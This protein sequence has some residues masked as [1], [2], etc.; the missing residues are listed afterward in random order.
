MLE[1]LA[2]D[3]T[4]LDDPDM[5]VR[6]ILQVLL[7]LFSAFF[8]ASETA[9]FSLSRLDLH[10]LRRTR[11][12][13]AENIHALLDQPRRLIISI[14]SGNELV[15]VA[16]AANLAGILLALYGDE[17]ALWINILVMVPLLLLFGEVIPKTI[18]VT[19]PV[20]TSTRLIAVPL[21][22]WVK[23]VSP[24]RWAVRWIADRLT[25]LL[26]GTEREAEHILHVDEFRSLV[27]EVAEEGELDATERALIYKLLE[28]DD[29]EI[30]EI[31]TPRTQTRFLSADMTVPDM[32]AN[33]RKFRHPRVPV[34]SKHRDN[35]VGIIHAEDVV[36]IVMDNVDLDAMRPEQLMHP[37]VFV[38]LTKKVDEMVDFFRTHNARA[39]V[40]LNEFGGVEGF[41]TLRA[42][43]NFIFG[44][45]TGEVRGQE[46]YKAQDENIYQV[47]GD[48][49]LKDFNNLTHFGIGDQRMTTIGGVVLRHLDRL[50]KVDD[51]VTVEDV[52]LKVS[53][54]DGHRIDRLVAGKGSDMQENEMGVIDL[55][56]NP[57]PVEETTPAP[58]ATDVVTSQQQIDTETA[59]VRE[60]PDN[61]KERS[62]N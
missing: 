48:M 19:N 33:F 59:S 52:T 39:A 3:T 22:T 41:I 62:A 55:M 57:A 61:A 4:R 23:L 60:A 16:A 40:V 49:K 2:F 56:Q 1:S 54:M 46:L 35:I 58:P 30:V 18:S 42:V 45:T 36:R 34:F 31:M 44:Q 8:S 25:T 15:N 20:G 7:F 10:Y 47:P 38:P 43:I 12:P 24:L 5:I 21:E 37:P 53:A 6:F 50:P 27:E 13:R 28:A 11:H 32:V 14:L 26:V 9:L 29:T 51:S 17:R